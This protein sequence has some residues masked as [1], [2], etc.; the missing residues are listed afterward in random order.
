M[1]KQ[2]DNDHE[3]GMWDG[4]CV[5]CDNY[6]R[7]SDLGLCED[8]AG[9]LE[10]DLIRQ[11]DWDHTYSGFALNDEQR[12]TLRNEIIRKHGAALELIEPDKPKHSKK[13]KPGK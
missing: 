11:N 1:V 12:Q 3:F 2:S 8:C 13:T 9:K 7:V 6:G 5:A 10:R 4:Q